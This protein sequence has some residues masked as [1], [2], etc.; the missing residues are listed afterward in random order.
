MVFFEKRLHE[1]YSVYKDQQLL[2]D[3]NLDFFQN[4]LF[5]V[6]PPNLVVIFV[7]FFFSDIRITEFLYYI[8]GIVTT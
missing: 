5:S 7:S 1:T 4:Y 2:A 3:K 6:I 8:E